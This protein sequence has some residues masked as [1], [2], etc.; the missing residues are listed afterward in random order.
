MGPPRL[1]LGSPPPQDGRITR[2]PY[3]PLLKFKL[4]WVYI[5]Y[6]W[7]IFADYFKYYSI[8]F[9]AMVHA[10][11]RHGANTAGNKSNVRVMQGN[12]ARYLSAWG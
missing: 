2:L 10:I 5:I 9:L 7:C 1:E 8:N 12:R 3:G 11:T 6:V 4:N